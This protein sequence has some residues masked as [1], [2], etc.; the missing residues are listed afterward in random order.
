MRVLVAS[1]CVLGAVTAS[2][3]EMTFSVDE[4]SGGEVAAGADAA[5]SEALANALRLYQREQYSEAAVQFQR[6]VE[7]DSRDSPAN[8]EKAQFFLAKSLYH[9]RF[10]RAALGIFDEI[11]QRP[12]HLYF[13]ES[14]PWLAQLATE[15]PEPAGIIEL[16]GRFGPEH[17]GALDRSETAA[18]HDHLLYLSGRYAYAQGDLEEAIRRLEEVSQSSEQF[19]HA[20]FFAGVTHV[21]LRRARPAIAAFRNVLRAVERS[22]NVPERP[23]MRDLAW[24][25]LARVYYTAANRT[26]DEGNRTLDETLLRNA[27]DAWDHIDPGSEYWLDAMFE[28]AWALYLSDQQSRAMGNIHTLFSPYFENAYYPEALVLKAVVFFSACQF[29][30]AEAMIQQFHERYDPVR[31]ELTSTLARFEDN[32]QFYRFLGEVRAGRAD[33]TPRI[34]GL[35]GTALSDRTL[36][37][38]LEYIRVLD[39]EQVQ[40]D[41]APAAFS[42]SSLADRIRQEVLVSRSFAVDRTGDLARGR[43]RRLVDELD[44]L[45][46]QIDT[47]E[48]EVY[49]VRRE[50]LSTEQASEADRI[51]RAGGLEV[52]VDEEHQIWPFDGEYWRDELPFYRQQVSS[53]CGR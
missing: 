10:F 1:L 7:G 9:L 47:V 34:R 38:H 40:I 51:R 42:S 48:V 15:L 31:E 25:S 3:Q 21:R 28:K 35:V 12:E 14:L 50:G 11:T 5:P 24:L 44:E 32:E 49:R 19:A 22:P 27:V 18:I 26:D 30:N 33:L 23:R 6:V 13:R 17:L 52:E 36:L 37:R 2:A 43:Y 16:V 41:R 20:R 29:E 53:I 46:N 8:L 45:M 39:D 4:T